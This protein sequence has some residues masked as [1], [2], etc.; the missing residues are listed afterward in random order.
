VIS[1]LVDIFGLITWHW[2]KWFKIFEW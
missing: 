1:N 2:N